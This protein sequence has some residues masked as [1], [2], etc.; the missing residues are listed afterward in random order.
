MNQTR[1][2][3]LMRPYEGFKPVIPQYDA[4]RRTEP[5]VSV[6]SALGLAECCANSISWLTHASHIPAATAAALPPEL[7]PADLCSRFDHWIKFSLGVRYGLITGPCTEF[8]FRDLNGPCV[9]GQLPKSSV[10]L[11][12]CRIHRSWF[13]R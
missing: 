2:D 13:C 3:L 5:P 11:A 8:T 4:G 9:S 12:P 7:P 1:T 6:P 10:Q